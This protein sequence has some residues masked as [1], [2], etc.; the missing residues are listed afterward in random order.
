MHFLYLLI[1]GNHILFIQK[2]N[3]PEFAKISFLNPN[4]PTFFFK[5]NIL[6]QEPQSNNERQLNVIIIKRTL[7]QKPTQLI[8]LKFL[9]LLSQLAKSRSLV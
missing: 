6:K 4:S 3:T 1:A 7:L 2:N 9:F 8:H 5:Q